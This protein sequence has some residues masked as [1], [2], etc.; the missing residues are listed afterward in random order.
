MLV[1]PRYRNT[2]ALDILTRNPNVKVTQK[3]SDPYEG[4][5]RTSHLYCMLP[6]A[7]WYRVMKE[8]SQCN[9]AY[10]GEKRDNT[11]TKCHRVFINKPAPALI[12][13]LPQ[14][15]G[16]LFKYDFS[17]RGFALEKRPDYT[18]IK[19]IRKEND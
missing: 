17:I 16:I 10:R 2:T 13:H 6:V 19:C 7:S 9:S 8:K 5:Q 1:F 18:N 3:N 15:L 11:K 12:S 14:V 4:P